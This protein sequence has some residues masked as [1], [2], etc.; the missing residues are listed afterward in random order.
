MDAAL[1]EST[2]LTVTAWA[3]APGDVRAG[4]QA[5]RLPRLVAHGEDSS[6][7]RLRRS[8]ESR[9]GEA[10]PENAVLTAARA[11]V[12]SRKVQAVIVA[13]PDT[14]PQ[15]DRGDVKRETDQRQRHVK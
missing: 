8:R 4:I 5:G 6:A 10:E 12:V 2:D 14:V 1:T 7:V 11:A 3:E 13:W 9:R 15:F